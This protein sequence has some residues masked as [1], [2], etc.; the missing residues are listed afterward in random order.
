MSKRTLLAAATV[1][2][3]LASLAV[4][5]YLL[6]GNRHRLYWDPHAGHC[7]DAIT[8]LALSTSSLQPVAI[9]V[10][11]PEAEAPTRVTI[12]Y[13]LDRALAGAVLE[14]ECIYAP[15]AS[16]AQSIIIGGMPIDDATLR[17]INASI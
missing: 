7:W 17:R 14:A 4:G 1:I 15:D 12:E 3:T 13:R 2:A 9:M 6:Q 16:E 10:T 11:R 5:L 8:T